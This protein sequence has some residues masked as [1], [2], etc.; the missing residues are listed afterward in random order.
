MK[1]SLI[2]LLVLFLTSCSSSK[3]IELGSATATKGMDV[4]QKAQ[5]IYTTLSEQ[6]AIDKSQQDKVKVLTHPSPSTMALP[7][8][9]APDF[10]KQ[11]QPRIQAYQNLFEVYK[12]FSLLADPKYSDKTKEAMAALQD[13]YDAIEKMP[14][15]PADVKTK[16]PNVLKMVG[17]AVQAKEVKKN[18]EILYVLSEV[19][20][21]LW[22]A[23]KQT[24]NEYIDLI[25][26]SYAE[27][28][29]TVDSKRYDVNKISQSNSE[30]YSDTATIIL[31]YRLRN[32]DDIMKQKN[33][34]KKQLVTFGQALEELTKAHAEI[35]KQ[36]TDISTVIS[37]LNKIEELLKDK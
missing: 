37:S 18:N 31:M 21:E 16:L 7:D 6:S 13:S 24:W 17:E 14:D 28:L 2:V 30:P 27:G 12:A 11:L 10:S 29:N 5:G 23:D 3:I 1:Q 19:Y 22:N 33:D 26:N 20:L 25:Y 34:L 15:L 36:S 4:S 8:T 9:K 35:A 32:R